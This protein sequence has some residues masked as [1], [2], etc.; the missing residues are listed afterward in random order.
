MRMDEMQASFLT[1][2]LK[3]INKW[4]NERQE[5]AKIYNRELNGVGDLVLP[6][7]NSDATHVY[8][9]YNVRSMF[10]DR[11]ISYLSEKGIGTLV[12][13]P[14]PPHLQ[15]CYKSLNYKV[16]SFP[17]AEEIANTSFSLPIWPGMNGTQIEYV[18]KSIKS[19]FI[20]NAKY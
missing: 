16:G 20:L 2:K 17:I 5:I 11:L 12:H 18:I 8:H 19:F 7:V 1:V 13:Y 15:L 14:I 3:H 6:Y 4:T 10:R 9:I